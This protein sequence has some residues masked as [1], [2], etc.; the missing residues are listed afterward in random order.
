MKNETEKKN[1]I[2]RIIIIISICLS[3]I[4]TFGIF[5]SLGT[6]FY[7]DMYFYSEELNQEL[8]EE[9]K[10]NILKNN[11]INSV[12]FEKK[13]IECKIYS[14]AN[15]FY[16]KISILLY[17]SE[18]NVEVK[19]KLKMDANN[20]YVISKM[21]YPS[22]NIMILRNTSMIILVIILMILIS[23]I[24]LIILLENIFFIF[25]HLKNKVSSKR[26]FR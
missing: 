23:T 13:G 21:S 4:I 24:I 7:K 1:D 10:K 11:E 3:L 8:L 16:K 19:I 25:E 26:T 6:Q 2:N 14:Q 15:P 9:A 18:K 12:Y 22:K 20:R 5:I 17:P